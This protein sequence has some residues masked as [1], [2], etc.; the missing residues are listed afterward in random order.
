MT[1]SIDQTI[2]RVEQLYQSV[3]GRDVPRIDGAPYAPIPPE[4]DAAEHVEQQFARLLEMMNGAIGAPAPVATWSPP[5]AIREQQGELVIEADLAGVVRESVR[6]QVTNN[7]LTIQGD[8][9]PMGGETRILY[10]ERPLG[11]FRRSVPLP[12][13][14]AS[15]EVRAELRDGVLRVWIPIPSRPA[16]GLQSIPVT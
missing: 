12:E 11:P 8:R 2:E 7:M 14:V 4:V 13:S 15:S 3:T 16:A 9:P 1:A 5:V 10:S 6:V